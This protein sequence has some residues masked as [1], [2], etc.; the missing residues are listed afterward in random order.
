MLDTVRFDLSD[1]L[2]HLF[3]DVDQ[4]SG[5]NILFPDYP[6]FNN[7][8]QSDKLDSRFLMRC[9]LRHHRIFATWS[10]QAGEP[11]IYGRSPV[12]CFTDMPLAMLVSNFSRLPVWGGKNGC[13]ALL[14]PKAAL[15]AIGARPVIHG[16]SQ[17][18]WERAGSEPY[19]ILNDH[20]L[21]LIEQYRY[22]ADSGW[23]ERRIGWTH[24][25]EWR[26]PYRGE[27]SH[28]DDNGDLVE[29][30]SEMPGFDWTQTQ[31]TGAGVLVQ[32]QEDVAKI[33]HDILT[34]VDAGAVDRSMFRFVIPLSAIEQHEGLHDPAH[35]SDLI[36]EHAVD[37]APWF[38]IADEKVKQIS[39]TVD[40]IIRKE[41]AASTAIERNRD[42]G[43]GKS[44]VWIV[45]NDS[46]LVRALV[47]SDRIMLS[48]GGRYLLDLADFDTSDGFEEHHCKA[49]AASLAAEFGVETSYFTVR[50]STSP[51]GIPSYT[52]F[53][54]DDT[55]PFFNLTLDS[56]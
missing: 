4:S 56:R 49:V 1:Y 15:H 19:R 40:R 39:A 22:V 25:N 30:L 2:I 21:P 31:I 34:L 38:A 43:Y 52:G 6:N 36:N 13:Y 54:F 28:F 17:T 24:E 42:D 47:A 53:F 46:P 35:V 3:R 7:I 20:L 23:G 5:E 48:E 14:F 16:L 45:D 29:S 18:P 12:V 50:G 41:F 55:H 8:D 27:Q 32:N 37:L 10:H 33:V 44:W 11:T 51:H 26:W 9:A